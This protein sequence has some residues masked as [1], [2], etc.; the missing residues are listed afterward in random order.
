MSYAWVGKPA[1]FNGTDAITGG[2]S[3]ECIPQSHC[4]RADRYTR[5]LRDIFNEIRPDM[6]TNPP[7]H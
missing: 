7:S 1:Q 6:L 2:D 4:A 3:G 5:I